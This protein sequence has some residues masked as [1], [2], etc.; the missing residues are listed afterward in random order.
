MALSMI[1]AIDNAGIEVNAYINILSMC[2]T[3]RHGTPKISGIVN[4]YASEA[5]RLANGPTFKSEKFNFDYVVGG[6]CPFV[7]IYA[8]LKTLDEFNT[9]TDLI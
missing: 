3:K 4:Y 1:T 7:Q 8:Y 6:D 2:I 5:L 9:A